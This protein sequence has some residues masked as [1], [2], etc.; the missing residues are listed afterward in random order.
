METALLDTNVLIHAINSRSPFQPAAGELVGRG[1]REWGK[2]CISPQNLVEFAAVV[3][4]P[5]LVENPLS[6]AQAAQMTRKLYGSRRLRKIYPK[7]GTVIRTIREG[8]S[9]GI[10]GPLWYDL[11]LAVTMAD[12]GVRRIITENVDDFK[13]F[14]FITVISIKEAV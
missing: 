8:A 14:P 7:R 11:Y 13:G 10:K 6:P 1:L 12:A 5:R 4:R 3:T 2:Y 9:L